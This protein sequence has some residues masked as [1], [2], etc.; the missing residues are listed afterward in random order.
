MSKQAP[1]APGQH[2]SCPEACGHLL[3]TVGYW[4]PPDIAAAHAGLLGRSCWTLY[5]W[6]AVVWACPCATHSTF[7][8]KG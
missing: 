6:Q 5:A 4:P 1:L 7:G 3:D 8:G 2:D